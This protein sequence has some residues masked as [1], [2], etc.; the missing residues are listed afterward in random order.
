MPE[1]KVECLTFP[2]TPE[3]YREWSEKVENHLEGAGL[4]YNW[5][6]VKST[7]FFNCS[8]MWTKYLKA[9]LKDNDPESNTYKQIFHYMVEKMWDLHPQ[10]KR[11]RN[12]LEIKRTEGEDI[13]CWI[14]RVMVARKNARFW[15]ITE[16]QSLFLYVVLNSGHKQYIE[17][18]MELIGSDIS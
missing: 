10:I 13:D 16:D 5:N 2:C 3:K 7:F 4:N 18:A 6:M 9:V 15:D 17:K 14:D 1:L 11:V 8:I 12:C